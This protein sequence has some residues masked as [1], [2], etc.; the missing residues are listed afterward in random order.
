MS[1]SRQEKI[2]AIANWRAT[3]PEMRSAPTLHQLALQIGAPAD[4][5][6][7]E[8]ASGP[9]VGAQV[10]NIVYA[11]AVIGAPAALNMLVQLAEKGNLRA[12]ECYLNFIYKVTLEMPDRPEKRPADPRQVTKEI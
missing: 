4:G 8:L 1:I 10:L 3:P 7:Y 11:S 12:I 2:N 9:E 5:T 6:F